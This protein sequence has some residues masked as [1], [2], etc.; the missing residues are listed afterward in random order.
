MSDLDFEK[1]ELMNATTCCQKV[2]PLVYDESLSYYEA[3]CKLTD[4]VNELVDIVNNLEENQN[5]ENR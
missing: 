2:L 5:G 3:I 1:K 4:K